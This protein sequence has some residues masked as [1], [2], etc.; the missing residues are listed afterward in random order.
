MTHYIG[1][2]K[3]SPQ[4]EQRL[5]SGSN[6]CNASLIC[7][8]CPPDIVCWYNQTC[9]AIFQNLQDCGF[10]QPPYGGIVDI[11]GSLIT[12][13]P[14]FKDN[15][16]STS[17]T[18]PITQD[19]S[20]PASS[21]ATSFTSP[22]TS[23]S[24]VESTFVDVPT[25]ANPTTHLS[26][27]GIAT[28]ISIGTQTQ[29]S[30]PAFS[31]PNGLDGGNPD[32]AKPLSTLQSLAA[33]STLL[34][35]SG[36]VSSS[37][38]QRLHTAQA[39]PSPSA[40]LPPGGL[41]TALP[42]PSGPHHP[43]IGEIIAIILGA[44]A[45]LFCIAFVVLFFLHRRARARRKARR[46]YS[47]SPWQ[48]IKPHIYDGTSGRLFHLHARGHPADSTAT[49]SFLVAICRVQSPRAGRKAPSGLGSAPYPSTRS[50]R[51][52]QNPNRTLPSPTSPRRARVLPQQV[53]AWT[54]LPHVRRR[55]R[56]PPQQRHDR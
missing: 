24:S 40:S 48:R 12:N 2:H 21:H 56:L 29:S 23:S 3:S 27:S 31:T 1:R 6:I 32:T 38:T 15:S 44:L 20:M 55:V 42:T 17:T 7:S 49:R 39:S 10:T 11:L 50:T 54:R 28:L 9:S 53:N 51:P 22:D 25:L 37:V 34:L 43:N 45:L 52:N 4:H 8:V 35:P 33:E 5:S 18:E 36:D 26:S 16:F 14:Q 19:S 41:S 13:C 30:A 46:T 47:G